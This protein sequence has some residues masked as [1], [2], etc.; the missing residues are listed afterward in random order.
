MV[1]ER[2]RIA[3]SVP[4][5]AVMLLAGL[6]FLLQANA[7]NAQL[8]PGLPAE[9]QQDNTP[10][11]DLQRLNSDCFVVKP[12]VGANADNAYRCSPKTPMSVFEEAE[13]VYSGQTVL[14]QP[15]INSVTET[16]EYSLIY[17]NGE[18]SHSV[19]KRPKQGDFRVQEEH[20][21]EVIACHPDSD[22]RYLGSACMKCLPFTTLYGRADI[23]RLDDGTPAIMELE[24][25]EP[26]LY[27]SFDDA[28][29]GRFAKAIAAELP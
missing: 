9:T 12:V 13:R 26:S 1:T 15:F 19:L 10:K 11:D 25:I 21:G 22:I 6:A 24:L 8:F 23:V 2:Q 27:V 7:T 29:P 20:G 5:C 18:Y 16:G 3:R 4:H 28:A 14:A 17:F